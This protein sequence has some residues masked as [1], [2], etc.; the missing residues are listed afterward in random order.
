M[1][2]DMNDT[3]FAQLMCREKCLQTQ[4]ALESQLYNG[5]YFIQKP[6]PGRERTLGTYETCHIDQVHGQ[7]WAWQVGA[8]RGSWTK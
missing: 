6:E 5:E 1:A 8:G 3:E 4:A 7:S 2:S